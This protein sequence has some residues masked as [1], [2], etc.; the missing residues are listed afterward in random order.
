M[1]GRP[2]NKKR[3]LSVRELIGHVHDIDCDVFIELSMNPSGGK[4]L[5]GLTNATLFI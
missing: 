4:K 2:S 5:V 1:I 3:Q